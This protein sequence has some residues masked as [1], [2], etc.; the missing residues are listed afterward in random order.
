MR[1]G[2]KREERGVRIARG[3]GSQVG[4]RGKG[5][6]PRARAGSL[7]ATSSH[8]RGY[9]RVVC[10]LPTTYALGMMLIRRKPMRLAAN[11]RRHLVQGA[12]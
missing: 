3:L 1:A 8:L 9:D 12:L 11:M 10:L 5:G 4:D 6:G 7:L 2:D